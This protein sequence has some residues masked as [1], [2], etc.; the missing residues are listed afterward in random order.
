ATSQP[1]P[2]GPRPRLL[3]IVNAPVEWGGVTWAAYMWYT[4]VNASPRHAREVLLH[5]LFHGS[6]QANRGLAARGPLPEHLDAMDGRYWLWR[7][8]RARGGRLAESGARRRT[9]VR[10]APAFPQAR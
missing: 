6:V 5:E 4:L 7:E 2:E 8:W 10:A 1:A 9:A 3:G